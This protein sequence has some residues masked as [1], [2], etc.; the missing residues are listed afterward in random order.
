MALY[1]ATRFREHPRWIGDPSERP[2]EVII[3]SGIID[4]VARGSRSQPP[5][6]HLPFFQAAYTVRML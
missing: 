6:S 4:Y 5:N 2:S 3:E 1:W